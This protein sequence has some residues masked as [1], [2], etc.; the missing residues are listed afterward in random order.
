MDPAV[1][2]YIR[3]SQAGGESGLATGFVTGED[4]GGQGLPGKRR[5]GQ[6]RRQG[7][8]REPPHRAGS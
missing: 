1:F 5:D 3:V 2:G 4:A 7:F 6:W 8:W